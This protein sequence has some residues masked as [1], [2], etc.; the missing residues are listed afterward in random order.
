MDKNKGNC[1]KALEHYTLALKYT[2][3][4][5]DVYAIQW[6]MACSKVKLETP[7][8]EVIKL[9]ESIPENHYFWSKI[10]EDSVFNPIKNT[11]EWR[12]LITKKITT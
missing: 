7:V 6:N 9:L 12:A 1:Y 5:D 10:Q 8:E 3:E 11:P 4:P 2:N